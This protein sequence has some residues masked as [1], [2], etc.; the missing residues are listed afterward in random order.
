VEI[1]RSHTG[2]LEVANHVFD[3]VANAQL[4]LGGENIERPCLGRYQTIVCN[5][6]ENVPCRGRLLS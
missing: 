2:F 6:V 1:V 4:F 3:H 5:E